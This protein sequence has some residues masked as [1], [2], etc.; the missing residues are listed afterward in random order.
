MAAG[1]EKTVA[2]YGE[3]EAGGWRWDRVRR[4]DIPHLMRLPAL[5]A[6]GVVN[7]GGPSTISPMN[8]GGSHGASW[9][10]VV[11][12][13]P[14]VRGWTI[15]PG[16]QSGNPASTLF[17]DRIDAWSAGRL[18]E[19]NVPGSAAELEDRSGTMTLVPGR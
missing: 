3:P 13:G 2:R 1:L 4:F 6:T 16:G 5:G 12:L 19:A 14:R 8:M 10:M 18:E 11:E 15:Y 17:E 7:S 9:R